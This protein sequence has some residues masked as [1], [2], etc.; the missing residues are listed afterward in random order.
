MGLAG[1]REHSLLVMAKAPQPGRTKT[2][3][4]P[5]LGP[6]GCARLQAALIRR[7][8]SLAARLT[9]DAAFLAYTPAAAGQTMRRL[10][11][12]GTITFPQRGDHLGQRL[13]AAT[14]TVMALRPGPLV[15]IGTDCPVLG[16]RHLWAA[17]RQLADGCDVSFGPAYD[18]GYYLVALA[19]PAPQLFDLRGSAW[20]GPEVLEQSL[21]A[22]TAAGLTVGVLDPEHD[23]DTPADAAA[24]LA[25]PRLPRDIARL[26]APAASGE[27][28]IA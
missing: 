15:I 21:A 3:L 27:G 5:L 22:A 23:L 20:G 6:E 9:A 13:T 18:G 19:A 16:P 7:A 12:A 4:E 24:A 8:V 1:G 10:V 2:R 11:P 25:D 26:L 17:A 28:A 14:A